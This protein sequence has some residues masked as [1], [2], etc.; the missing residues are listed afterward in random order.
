MLALA[1]ACVI[2]SVAHGYDLYKRRYR[3]HETMTEQSAR[4]F[5]G[6]RGIG[7]PVTDCRE[8]LVVDRSTA[9]RKHDD[10]AI[11]ELFVGGEPV[12]YGDLKI[13]VRWPDDPQRKLRGAQGIRS[14]ANFGVAFWLVRYCERHKDR[15]EDVNGMGL[16]CA[17]HYGDMQFLHAMASKPGETAAQTREKIIVWSRFAYDYATGSFED[18]ELLCDVLLKYPEIRPAVVG[19]P[20]L[21]ICAGD[22]R[23]EPRQVGWFFGFE[24]RKTFGSGRCHTTTTVAERRTAALGAILHMIQ[25]SYSQ[26]HVQ[27]GRCGDAQGVPQATIRLTP[28]ERYH[29][30]SQQ[31]SKLHSE[32]DEWPKVAEEPDAGI[33]HPVV[34]GARVLEMMADGQTS[35]ELEHY[36][37]TRVLRPA[38]TL[39]GA[40]PGSGDCYGKKKRST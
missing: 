3:V 2:P 29:D 36:L 13:A 10:L 37:M 11:A 14:A 24:C 19:D 9:S 35:R 22:K 7:R 21:F 25:D 6:S 1:S 38:D 8:N 4:C 23:G 39:P 33:D 26:S 28:V 5:A 17:S 34:A 15:G 40:A 12:T 32:S 20:S 31:R 18:D 30:Y 27:R 16:L